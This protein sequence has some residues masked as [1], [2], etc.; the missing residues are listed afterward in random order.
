[1]WVCVLCVYVRVFIIFNV[2]RANRLTIENISISRKKNTH[3]HLERETRTYDSTIAFYRAQQL[4][5]MST[6]LRALQHAA[7]FSPEKGQPFRSKM[8]VVTIFFALIM[9][10]CFGRIN[11]PSVPLIYNVFSTRLPDQEL[12]DF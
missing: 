7:T 5:V 6:V 1:M 2:D 12:R 3:K 8:D 11:P 10:V 4:N 9:C